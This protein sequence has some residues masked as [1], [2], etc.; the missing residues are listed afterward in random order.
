[1]SNYWFKEKTKQQHQQKH[2]YSVTICCIIILFGQETNSTNINVKHIMFVSVCFVS[3]FLKSSKT[4]ICRQFHHVYSVRKSQGKSKYYLQIH[5]PHT[6]KSA[7]SCPILWNSV[8]E[9]V[10]IQI[11]NKHNLIVPPG[12]GHSNNSVVHSTCTTRETRKKVLF[13]KAKRDSRESR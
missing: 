8:S 1:M 5:L 11:N 2:T 9:N 10:H 13:F 7:L 3:V 6:V 4:T 12:R